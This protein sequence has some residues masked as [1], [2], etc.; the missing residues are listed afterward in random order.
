MHHTKWTVLSCFGIGMNKNAYPYVN[1]C[2][3]VAHVMRWANAQRAQ[4]MWNRSKYFVSLISKHVPWVIFPQQMR[5]IK[6]MF[7]FAMN[8]KQ[9]RVATTMNDLLCL[10]RNQRKSKKRKKKWFESYRFVRLA[11]LAAWNGDSVRLNS[12]ICETPYSHLRAIWFPPCAVCSMLFA[13]RADT[14]TRPSAIHQPCFV[15]LWN[16]DDNLFWFHFMEN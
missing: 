1:A 4:Q 10:L 5:K 12:T 2:V 15:L 3:C 13:T 9:H 11:T 7:R 16:C 6:H 14:H 8:R